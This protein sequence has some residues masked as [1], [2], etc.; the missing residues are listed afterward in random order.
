MKWRTEAMRLQD[1]DTSDQFSATLVSTERI[2]PT[3]TDEV[4]ELEID[5]GRPTFSAHAGQSV[6]VLAPGQREFGQDHHFRLYTVAD[7]PEQLERSTRIKLCVKRCSYVDE[8]SGERYQGVASN[9]LCDLRAGAEITMTGPYGTPFEIPAELDA[10]LLLIGA[11]TGIAPFR[12]F[13]KRLYHDVPDFAGKVLLFHGARSG[14]DLIYHNSEKD[15][16]S[17][18]Y[19]RGTFEA[20]QA[21]SDRPHWT[22]AVDWQGAFES[23]AQ[24]LASLLDDAKTYVYVAGLEKIRDRL[25]RTLAEVVGSE[26]RWA[27]RK[28]ELI[29]GHRWVELLY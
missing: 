14:L 1:Y 23:R 24:E 6:G 19:D 26:S 18:Y 15:D 17:Q 10:T 12:A 7:L 4:R 25:D 28:A 13:C 5:I 16:F 20:I 27:R 8:Y 3:A 9:W 2:T 22:D 29:A 21:L 11:G